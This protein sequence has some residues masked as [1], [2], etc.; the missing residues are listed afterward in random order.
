M[1]LRLPALALVAFALGCAGP[2]ATVTPMQ[3][4]P[5]SP[6]SDELVGVNQAV[7]ILDSSG[8]LDNN[9]FP[10]EKALVE[11]FVGAMPSGQ[12]AASLIVF[13]GTERQQVMQSSFERAGLKK[14]AYEARHLKAGTPLHAVLAEVAEDLEGKSGRLA[15]IIFS[16][17]KQTG[18]TGGE[19]APQAVLD[20]AG[21]L[22]EAYKGTTCIHTVQVGDDPDGAELL[23]ALAGLTNCGSARTSTSLGNVASLQSF[24]RKVFFVPAPP[25]PPV[26]ARPREFARI[27]FEFDKYD[28]REE[29]HERLAAV[30]KALRANASLKLRVD[31]FTDNIGP[32]EHNKTLSVNR[33]QTAASYLIERG[34][35]ESQLDIEGFGKMFPLVP[36]DT[37]ED[38]AQNRR[39]EFQI[40]E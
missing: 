27:H 39:V 35:P 10:R 18:D 8:S 34:V 2:S 40:I 16:D 9:V 15:V 14:G 24:E 4:S 33:A 19:I 20:S 26:A 38:R 29:D 28:I 12:Y 32:A 6:G 5:V 31:G 1:L 22:I 17:G 36:N 23:R 25:T 13:G 7:V 21:A 30:A 11:S 37:P 3:A